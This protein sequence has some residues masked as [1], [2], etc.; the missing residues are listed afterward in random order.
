[1]TPPAQIKHREVLVKV[2]AWVD[3]E[4]AGLVRALNRFERVQTTS[5]CED[6]TG[7]DDSPIAVV[8]FRY[9]DTWF[10]TIRFSLWLADE[11]GRRLEEAAWVSIACYAQ[12]RAE[13]SIH[14]QEEATQR[15][16]GELDAIASRWNPD[17]EIER[18]FGSVLLG[19]EAMT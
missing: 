1:M 11:L 7:G 3:E 19:N 5:S 13:A 8:T 18:S 4:V 12:H 2:N 16:V 17:H 10:D 14:V 6:S 9:G 15:I